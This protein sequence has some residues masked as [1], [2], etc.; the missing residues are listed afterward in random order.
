MCLRNRVCAPSSRTP[1]GCL[2]SSTDDHASG[3]LKGQL[4]FGLT[5]EDLVGSYEDLASTN[6]SF[7]SIT[8]PADG[9]PAGSRLTGLR[10][11]NFK[12]FEDIEVEFGDF[13]LLVGTNN[14]GKSTILQAIKL[15]DALLRQHF[16][17]DDSAAPHPGR[18]FP[19]SLLPVAEPRDL[20]YRKRW[21]VGNTLVAAKLRLTYS[22]GLQFEFGLRLVY[23]AVNSR[24]LSSP[25]FLGLEELARIKSFAPVLVPSSF[26]VVPHEERRTQGRVSTLIQTGR[27]NE[28]VRNMLHDLRES[29]PDRFDVLRNLLKQHFNVD[30]FATHF[31]DFAD[32]F[33]DARYDELGAD[34][35]LFS[36]G[37]GFVQVL[38]LL[39]FTLHG[40]HGMILLDEPDAHLHSSM[41]LIVVEMLERL[42]RQ[43]NFQVLIST[44]SKEII[45]FVAPTTLIPVSSGHKVGP[46]EPH[47]SALAMLEEMG[48]VDNIDL[49]SLFTSKRCVFV[50]GKSDAGYLQRVAGKIGSTV[51]EG[52]SRVVV[53]RTGGV[54]NFAPGAAVSVFS[55]LAGVQ[56]A[57]FALRDRDGRS[58]AHRDH[59]MATGEKP[60]VHEL[61]CVESYFVLPS[62]FAR[63]VAHDFAR[64]ERSGEPPSEADL[65]DLVLGLT[66]ELRDVTLDHVANALD[67]HYSK[68]ERRFETPAVLNS[69]AREIVSDAWD[70]LETR[71]RYVPG[72]RLLARCRDQVKTLF[73][74]SLT[75]GVIVEF[76]TD[77]D[78]R[79]LVKLVHLCE[80]LAP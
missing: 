21:R 47:V 16:P 29:S 28:A 65:E 52:D 11:E 7:R 12:G 72:K 77:D 6:A 45:N 35:D 20:W 50:E 22:G 25:S 14:S 63:A 78:L 53:V 49:Y 8:A 3:Q 10:L 34:L 59:V 40:T 31:D 66:D 4:D 15:G 26:G 27:Q 80:D 61:D 5:V 9:V 13:N 79:P 37:A 18:T 19:V 76:A 71:L 55:S 58:D 24:I 44:H 23:G 54:D 41:Q 32:Q 17:S 69:A 64:L 74:T 68:Y 46:L 2:V 75:D 33:I 70:S 57:H 43:Y 38:Q 67:A 30:L 51:F 1:Y 39:T 62:A 73:G 60:H 36:A 42:A 56:L 48:S